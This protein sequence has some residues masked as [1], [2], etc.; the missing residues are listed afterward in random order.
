MFSYFTFALKVSKKTTT[1]WVCF[2]NVRNPW[3][4][5]MSGFLIQ[6][7]IHVDH[8]SSQMVL[9]WMDPR[10]SYRFW[11]LAMRHRVVKWEK[12]LVFLICDRADSCS[13]GNS[14]PLICATRCCRS[15]TS[16]LLQVQFSLLQC[17]GV[18]ASEPET[19]PGWTKWSERL[20]L[21]WE[22]LWKC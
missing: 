19:K 16:L 4:T 13:L 9:R 12:L 1:Q 7:V 5:E 22:P 17:A 18:V 14:G 10:Q 15:F 8:S 20:A 3:V 2:F 11:I 6:A 21:F